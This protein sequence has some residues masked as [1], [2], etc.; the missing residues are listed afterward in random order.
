MAEEMYWQQG[1]TRAYP[2][3]RGR[4]TADAVIIG[5][6]LTGLTVALWLCR[7]GL[8][9]I[10]LEA[11]TLGSG[12]SACCLGRV[13]L[14]GGTSL[15]RLEKRFGQEGASACV[16]ARQNA[17]YALREMSREDGASF[18]WHTLD[19]RRSRSSWSRR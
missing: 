6:G 8:R 3:L 9:V 10:L 4:R 1:D 17:L 7:A 2:A 15:A 12:S 11:R 19:D 14:L 16:S 18:G 13:S 5:G